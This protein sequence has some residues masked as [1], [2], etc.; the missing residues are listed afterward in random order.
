M[1]FSL[2]S[3]LV[4]ARACSDNTQSDQ[5][6]SIKSLSQS[7][8]TSFPLPQP[9][10]DLEPTSLARSAPM[11]M[12]LPQLEQ[13]LAETDFAK[14]SP[15]SFDINKPTL[16]LQPSFAISGGDGTEYQNKDT[17]DVSEAA[18]DEMTDKSDTEQLPLEPQIYPKTDNSERMKRQGDRI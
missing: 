6:P 17:E 10:L 5:F 16:D 15:M 12:S 11:I 2:V 18:K 13:N 7:S 1:L 8:L 3:V 4:I 9:S 14:N